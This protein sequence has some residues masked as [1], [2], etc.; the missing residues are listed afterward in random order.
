MPTLAMP[1]NESQATI[2]VSLWRG[3]ESFLELAKNFDA[4]L[5]GQTVFIKVC[6]KIIFPLVNFASLPVPHATP[7]T[8]ICEN[9]VSKYRPSHLDR[10]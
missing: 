1:I 8:L 5:F 10:F 3:V 9:I 7:P 6:D 2:H 4:V